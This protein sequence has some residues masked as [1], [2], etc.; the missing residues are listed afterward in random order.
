MVKTGHSCPFSRRFHSRLCVWISAHC[1]IV[2]EF[3]LSSRGRKVSTR[4]KMDGRSML[5]TFQ[6]FLCFP[7]HL[8]SNSTKLR[9]S[10]NTGSFYTPWAEKLIYWTVLWSFQ[11]TEISTESFKTLQNM[12]GLWEGKEILCE[13]L[14]SLDEIPRGVLKPLCFV[15]GHSEP[16]C[17]C[18]L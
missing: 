15:N 16:S 2:L 18:P 7:F 8:P 4:P 13:I 12:T 1:L 6:L 17:K 14:W 3:K 9:L 5:L 11:E 10:W